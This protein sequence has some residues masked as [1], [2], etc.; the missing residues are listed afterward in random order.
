M[1]EPAPSSPRPLARFFEGILA[2]RSF[3]LVRGFLQ[4]KEWEGLL[5]EEKELLSQLFLL[6]AD[7]T[8]ATT[9]QLS[10]SETPKIT[11]ERQHVLDCLRAACRLTPKSARVWFRLGSYLGLQED[12]G[13]LR[14]GMVALESSIA[15]DDGFFDAHYAL[16]SSSL[17]YGVVSG[18]PSYF[19]LSHNAF[20]AAEA[21]V[22]K[23]HGSP[24]SEFYWHWGIVLFLLARESGEPEDYFKALQSYT[25]AYENGLISHEFYN[26]YANCLVEVALL[27]GR[28]D[29]IQ[30]MAIPLY[31]ESLLALHLTDESSSDIKREGMIK[32]F[33]IACCYH[34]LFEE[35]HNKEYFHKADHA[36]QSAIEYL[37]Q[38]RP[39]F[40]HK[41]GQLCFYA[42]RLYN[43]SDL[44]HRAVNH[45][46]TAER[47]FLQDKEP[48][49]NDISSSVAY[50]LWA[51]A[52]L[53][54]AEF[55]NAPHLLSEAYE[56]AEKAF[57]LES[58]LP[59]KKIHPEVY[60]A[61]GWSLYALG[62]YF[63]EK[64]YYEKARDIIHQ[65]LLEH[66]KS[67]SL[68]YALA[69]IKLSLGEAN[70]SELSMKESLISFMLAS[71]SIYSQFP[72]F[73]T[74]WGIALLSLADWIQDSAFAEEAVKRLERVLELTDEIDS[75]SV[76]NLAC[77]YNLLG[78]LEQSEEYIERALFLFQ[79]LAARGML[80]PNVLYHYAIT[81]FHM[82]EILEES[83]SFH[84]AKSLFEE[85]LMYDSEDE[86]ALHEYAL[87]LIH[88]GF[89]NKTPETE[90]IPSEWFTAEEC[91]I[92]ASKA[93]VTAALY[94]L[95]C[96][97]SLM[98]NYYEALEK[99]YEALEMGVLPLP[100]DMIDDE[101]LSLHFIHTPQFHDFFS[102]YQALH[103][104]DMGEYEENSDENSDENDAE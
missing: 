78:E 28:D 43:E 9:Q 69:L 39:H 72:S 84:K 101:W 74:D 60:A 38:E 52:L 96:I 61:M 44:M 7:Q 36:F 81:Q 82:A 8:L 3:E 85:Y 56:K 53:F 75:G 66:A 33:N 100:E 63:Q 51:E 5:S 50:A 29:F 20:I 12:I 80:E 25:K 30:Q 19:L 11:E 89:E 86:S 47:C 24:P 77:A 104:D 10:Q 18:E 68:W 40:W 6:S 15:L 49:S 102:F 62:K 76:F 45:F 2:S 103:A 22:N 27:I 14:D 54:L 21:L 31:E 97:Y 16:A 23:E 73:W 67:A 92:R 58:E 37:P 34:H 99:L 59:P 64:D 42:G 57:L 46:E 65:G 71:K 70:D 93:G 95:A 35:T 88:I 91:L 79:E 94:H 32:N 90:A 1:T 87:C 41:W 13:S 26:D 55:E 48:G 4:E 17:R 83:E 98:G